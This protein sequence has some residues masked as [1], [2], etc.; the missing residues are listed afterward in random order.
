MLPIVR[1]VGPSH[2]GGLPAAMTGWPAA[3]GE[4][5]PQS[6]MGGLTAQPGE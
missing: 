2:A 6:V 1:E 3:G 5:K 4:T